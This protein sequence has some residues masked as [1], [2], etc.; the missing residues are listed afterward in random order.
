MWPIITRVRTYLALALVIAPLVACRP[1]AAKTTTEATP[2]TPRRG[3]EQD[4]GWDDRAL[5]RNGLVGAEQGVLDRLPGASVYHVDVQIPA[6]FSTLR[7]HDQVRYTNQEDEP[8][9]ALYF[10]LFPNL[11]GGKTTVS[12][13][14]VDGRDV[15]PLYEC[16]TTTHRTSG[17]SAPLKCSGNLPSSIAG[18]I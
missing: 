11:A 15:E 13:V 2:V 6:D 16:A 8:L 4:V 18:A 5:F 9:D 1:Q 12:A 10:Q 14:K 7:G 17:G 3:S